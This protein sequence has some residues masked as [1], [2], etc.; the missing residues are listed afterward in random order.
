MDWAW[1]KPV[2]TRTSSSSSIDRQPLKTLDDSSEFEQGGD[3]EQ[4]VGLWR[5]GTHRLTELDPAP[6]RVARIV[7]EAIVDELRRRL[8]GPFLSEELARYYLAHGIDWCFEI[9]MRAAPGDPD[10][11]DL[12][13]VAN[14]AFATYLRRASDQGGGRRHLDES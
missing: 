9:A 1:S 6:R 4:I 11:W 2:S 8:G 5:E 13:T 12:S 7:V 14:A 3:F 10:A